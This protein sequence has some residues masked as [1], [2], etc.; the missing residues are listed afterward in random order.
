MPDIPIHHRTAILKAGDRLLL[1]MSE[2]FT[3]HSRVKKVFA[4]GVLLV[5]FSGHPRPDAGEEVEVRTVEG[6]V[7]KIYYLQVKDSGGSRHPYLLLQRNP[8]NKV[9]R[10]RR[11]F[12]IPYTSK[13]V[14]RGWAE[15]HF[16]SA[17]F[18]DLSLTSARLASECAYPP[19]TRVVLVL[20][21]EGFPE[22]EVQGRVLRV[23][24]NPVC[25][26]FFG[27]DLYGLVVIFEA[28]TRDTAK[29]LTLFLWNH[30]RRNY[31]GQMRLLFDIGHRKQ[32]GD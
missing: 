12:R 13:T 22:H 30:L 10:R 16:R 17:V 24:K 26:D 3:A 9:N 29:H 25:T 6:P 18:Y 28:M 8:G 19:E 31:Q 4:D 11:G 1:A 2:D 5:S 14:I 7:R 32:F 15:R 20:A 21:L 23:S 27:Q